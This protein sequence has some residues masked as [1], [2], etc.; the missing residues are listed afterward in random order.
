MLA[1]WFGRPVVLLSS[2]RTGIQ[3]LL[4]LSGMNRHRDDLRVPPFLSRCVLNAVTYHAFPVHG[5]DS[6][7]GTLLY[8]QYGFT[9]RH[10][11]K[12]FVIEVPYG[13]VVCRP[14]D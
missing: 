3:L 6:A 1:E 13:L 7:T 10:E 5:G 14:V 12:G 8:H 11:P 4:R 2:G 9:Q